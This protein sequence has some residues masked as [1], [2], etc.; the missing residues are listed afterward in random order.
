MSDEVGES[1]GFTHAEFGAEGFGDEVFV[2]QVGKSGG[3]VLKP[4]EQELGHRH[5][6]EPLGVIHDDLDV[7][8]GILVKVDPG[9][10]FGFTAG[11]SVFCGVGFFDGGGLERLAHIDEDLHPLGAVFDEGNVFDKFLNWFWVGHFNGYGFSMGRPTELPHSVQDP[12]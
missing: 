1:E 11:N 8:V 2:D 6:R 9:V 5:G 10:D 7:K 12:S 4:F 3:L